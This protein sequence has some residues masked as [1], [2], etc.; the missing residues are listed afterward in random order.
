MN[1]LTNEKIRAKWHKG[2]DEE[3]ANRYESL[4]EATG[5]ASRRQVVRDVIPSRKEENAK[6]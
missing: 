4:R 5:G 1:L 6:A 3:F 2:K